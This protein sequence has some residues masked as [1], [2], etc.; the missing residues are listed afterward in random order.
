MTHPSLKWRKTW[1]LP[2][3]EPVLRR[4]P[5]RVQVLLLG[6]VHQARSIGLLESFRAGDEVEVT[7]ACGLTKNTE[8][9]RYYDANNEAIR[10]VAWGALSLKDPY[11]PPCPRCY[12]P[13]AGP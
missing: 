10:S 2:N 12:P 6:T 4:E 7:T 11:S 1:G 3:P 5:Q 13:E 9:W 8:H